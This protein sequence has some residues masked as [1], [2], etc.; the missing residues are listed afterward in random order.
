MTVP[1]LEARQ[2]T[3]RFGDMAALRNVSFSV[4]SGEI[5]ALCGENGA[6]KSTLMRV[7]SGYFPP[8]SYRR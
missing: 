5:H 7:L 4:H 6:G 3:K 1:L 8:R 2:I